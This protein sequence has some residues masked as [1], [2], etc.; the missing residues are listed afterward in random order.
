MLRVNRNEEG[1]KNGEL[2]IEFS[3]EEVRIRIK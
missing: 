1:F 2:N 3:V